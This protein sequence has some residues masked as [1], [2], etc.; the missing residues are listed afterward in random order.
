MNKNNSKQPQQPQQPL[1]Q[2]NESLRANDLEWMVDPVFGFD[3]YDAKMGSNEDVCTVHFYVN[4]KQAA[5]DLE[6]FIERGYD[7]VLDADASPGRD[8]NGKFLVFVEIERNKDLPTKINIL[9]EA[10]DRLVVE[11]KWQIETKTGKYDF[12]QL[13]EQ[14]ALTSEDYAA[15]KDS[16]TT[17]SLDVALAP[18][19]AESIQ[20]ESNLVKIAHRG[21]VYEYTLQNT[22]PQGAARLDESSLGAARLFEIIMGSKYNIDV[23]EGK[24]CIHLTDRTLVLQPNE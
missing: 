10:L 1:P 2:L 15:Q 4:D 11:E 20:V 14:V 17:E 6:G 23:V 16:A 9:K 8:E 19:A 12:D 21:R 13:P 22:V 18:H 7:W 24:L 5:E 3:I